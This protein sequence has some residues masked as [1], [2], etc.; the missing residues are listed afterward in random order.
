MR[1]KAR[2]SDITGRVVRTKV[3]R[4]SP[5]GKHAYTSRKIALEVAGA[6]RRATG[7]NIQAYKC[8]RGCH[9]FHIGHPPGEP[10]KLVA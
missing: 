3:V 5:C 7:E 8:R 2:P 4:T 9:C 1:P 10:R 6:Q